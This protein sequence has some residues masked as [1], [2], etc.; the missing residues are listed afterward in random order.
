MTT[1]LVFDRYSTAG[2]NVLNQDKKQDSLWGRSSGNQE[3]VKYDSQ[4]VNFHAQPMPA[5]ACL[6][7][8]SLALFWLGPW[9]RPLSIPSTQQATSH[10]GI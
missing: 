4:V 2:R 8:A 9:A 10:N 6:P 1:Y 5:T 7:A 3:P